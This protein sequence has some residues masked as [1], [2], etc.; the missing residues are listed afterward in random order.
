MATIQLLVTDE[1]NRRALD[2]VI[3]DRH[4]TVTAAEVQD[5]DLYVVDEPT[6]PQY[7]DTLQR[8]TE[9][10][11]PVFC[12][13]MLIRRG[14]SSVSVTLPDPASTSHP[15]V[16][17]EVLT[18]PVGRQALG[19][20]IENLL[21]RRRQTEQ[22][23]KRTEQLEQLASALR[24]EL[25]NPLSVLE[26]SLDRARDTCA[27]DDFDRC[28]QA[29]NRME[30]MLEETL[31]V[32]EQGDLEVSTSIVDVGAVATNCWDII[33]EPAADL[34]VVTDQTVSADETRLKQLF[35]N[36]FRNAVEHA[37]PEVAV[38]VGPLDDGF[39]VED[40]GPG[41]PEEDRT[42]VFEQGYSTSLAGSGLGLAVVQAVVDAHGWHVRLTESQAGGTR[43]EIT[44]V[45][46]RSPTD[47][48][49]DG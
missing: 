38:T 22:L 6:F 15:F 9:D 48:T 42:R 46:Q 40:D 3:P 2:A 43:F 14:Q 49:N 32:V 47:R 17:D 5:A 41:I 35:E 1:G 29:I 28:Q 31:L 44:G 25:R 12:P 19:R 20:A 24:H 27:V 10:A 45:E 34:D 13:I 33:R 16:V 30:R 7:R 36:L 21:A 37:G 8:R 39:Y 26:L 11:T 23:Q 4:A 18:A